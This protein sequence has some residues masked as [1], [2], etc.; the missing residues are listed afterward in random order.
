MYPWPLSMTLN[1]LTWITVMMIFKWINIIEVEQ[2]S[3]VK[4]NPC[5]GARPNQMNVILITQDD[6][7][8]WKELRRDS[9]ELKK[10]KKQAKIA[11]SKAEKEKEIK[12]HSE[13]LARDA[14]KAN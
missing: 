2:T 6:R 10:L 12:V 4:C 14:N 3:M 9:L 8:A 11:K 5:L 1:I 7:A 13:L